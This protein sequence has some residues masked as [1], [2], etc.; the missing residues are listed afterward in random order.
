MITIGQTPLAN[1]LEDLL[2]REVNLQP[3]DKVEPHEA[4]YRGMVT[5]E[6]DLVAVIGS[7]L[8]FAHTTG[9]ALALI[10]AG[11]LDGLDQP[12]DVLLEIYTEV[13]NVM[14]RLVNEATIYR[15]RLDPGVTHSTE[16]LEE[17]IKSGSMIEACTATIAGYGTGNLGIWYNPPAEAFHG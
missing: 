2:G 11:R 8:E 17:V 15:T 7:D 1:L 5:D 16:A 3:V 13:A 6:D 12:D 10:P 9:A 14:S 4:T